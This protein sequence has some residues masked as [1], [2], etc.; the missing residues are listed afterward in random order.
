MTKQMK[1]ELLEKQ[2]YYY[3][4]TIIWQDGHETVK[5]VGN[6]LS[7]IEFMKKHPGKKIEVIKQ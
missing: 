7:A 4:I 6:K 2:G 3:R 1:D 5:E